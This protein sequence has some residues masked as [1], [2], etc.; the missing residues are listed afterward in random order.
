MDDT[1]SQDPLANPDIE[2]KGAELN[3]RDSLPATSL[4][5]PAAG[6]VAGLVGGALFWWALDAQGMMSSAP[7]L[8]GVKLSGGD[9]ML[10]LAAS[11]ALG[12]GFGA[13]SRYQPLG[14]AAI[15]STGLL[16]G[17]VWWIVG[18]NT[19]GPLFD[20]RGPTWSLA[21]ATAA[22]PSL[23]GH[24]LYG[25][26]TGLGFHLLVDA[27]LRL[28]PEPEVKP[29]PETAKRRVVILGG[30][31]GG[32]SVAQR[33]EQIYSGNPNLEI[34][35][36]SQS[37]YLLFTPMLA[38]VA[39]SALEAQHI[40]APIRACCPHTQFFRAGVESIDTSTQT[41]RISFGPSTPTQSLGYDHLVLALGSV[42][43]YYGLPGLAEH[44]FT[45]KTLED[46][47]TLRNHVI[48]LLEGADI[49]QDEGRRR[50]QLT[51]SV[52]GGGFAG[53]ETMAEL[54]DLVHSV[55]R[56]YPNIRKSELRFVLIHGR[57]RILP[58]LSAKLGEYALRKLQARGIEFLLGARVA[59]ATADA[60]LIKD[61]DDV[62]TFTL[63][64]TAGNQPNPLLQTLP[65]ERNRA[66]AV[67]VD[68]TLRV[69]GM[70]NVWGLGDC[71][72]VPDPDNEGQP[73]PP[74]AQHALREG[75]VV[76]DNITAS[77]RGKPLKD[78]RFRALGVLVGLGYRTAAAEIRGWRFSGLLA[79][80]MWRTIYL[81][82][83][84]GMEKKVR[85]AL[86]WAIDLF[87]PRDIVLTSTP[88]LS[89]RQPIEGASPVNGAPAGDTRTEVLE[90]L[91]RWARRAP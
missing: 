14:H 21:E 28:W 91:P 38:E 69:A 48:A 23:I 63:V 41:V 36:V 59:G 29:E 58:E 24:L 86:D 26:L 40:S 3:I 82:K 22:F 78:F 55:L 46:A 27:S 67:V 32:V 15:I 11:I 57:D 9:V 89:T 61:G 76:G 49:E 8:L 35:L 62:P 51:F 66:G 1:P 85:V 45:L 10:H 74:T 31:F 64:W 87:F 72:E 71:A 73:Y 53:T 88:D 90:E 7:G 47:T 81:S 60:V 70:D 54:F 77:I 6:G 30:G 37:N 83:L 33:L 2:V 42:P 13:L 44:S 18:P 65:G 68:A 5:G 4:R 20:G 79:W 17:L 52:A 25:G 75:K 12:A 39:S 16:Y 84:P 43:N 19:L 34:S 80:L 56:Y 50:R